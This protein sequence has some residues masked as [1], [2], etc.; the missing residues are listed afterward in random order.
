MCVSPPSRY[1]GSFPL[2][3]FRHHH[4][5]QKVLRDNL[6]GIEAYVMRR[7][8]V[9]WC[10]HILRISEKRVAKR[11]FYSELMEDKEVSHEKM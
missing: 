8:L 1:S 4:E 11:I 2:K 7:Q 10:R 6:D 5:D 9:W 3:M